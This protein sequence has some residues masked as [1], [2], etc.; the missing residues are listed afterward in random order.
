MFFPISMA[1]YF[2]QEQHHIT[3]GFL[4]LLSILLFS[5]AAAAALSPS[6]SPSPL[7]A[8]LRSKFSTTNGVLSS[9]NPKDM[10]A[11]AAA[12]ANV[13]LRLQL[14]R[15][16]PMMD[17]EAG[18]RQRREEVDAEML[19]YAMRRLRQEGRDAKT[20]Q[21]YE[22]RLPSWTEPPLRGGAD[23]VVRACQVMRAEPGSLRRRGLLFNGFNITQGTQ[24]HHQQAS[25]AE[26][27]VVPRVTTNITASHH[28]L[29]T[30]QVKKTNKKDCLAI[31]VFFVAFLLLSTECMPLPTLPQEHG[32]TTNITA[33]HHTLETNQVKKKQIL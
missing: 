27:L 20:G 19:D 21:A 2:C 4:H 17:I 30:S 11:A 29:E 12:A 9:S 8:R 5:T 16:E 15:E 13:Q 14:L 1:A 25:S 32:V 18:N 7:A 26:T 31:E 33:P 23:G 22:V 28:T 24:V 10:T 3:F 6:P